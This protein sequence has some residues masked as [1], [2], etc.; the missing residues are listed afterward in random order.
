ML[1]PDL[2]QSL[3]VADNIV[4]IESGL[5]V[6]ND[7]DFGIPCRVASHV[8]EYTFGNTPVGQLV[9]GSA[10]ARAAKAQSPSPL[11]LS[12]RKA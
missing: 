1:Y 12:K 9:F 7:A 3:D 4:R 6:A 5:E 8:R 10:A 11:Q 2:E